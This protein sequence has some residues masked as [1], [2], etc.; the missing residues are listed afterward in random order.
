MKR[1]LMK[2]VFKFLLIMICPMIVNANN[3]SDD[4]V[5]TAEY[6]DNY[7][8]GNVVKC[9]AH[10]AYAHQKGIMNVSGKDVCVLIQEDYFDTFVCDDNGMEQFQLSV[11]SSDGNTY[12]GYGCRKPNS[13]AQIEYQQKELYIGYSDQP[14]DWIEDECHIISGDSIAFVGQNCRIEAVK[15]GETKLKV[16]NNSNR[17]IRYY[18]YNVLEAYQSISELDQNY[19]YGSIDQCSLGSGGYRYG[20]KVSF[21]DVTFCASS[22]SG[23]NYEMYSVSC[24]DAGYES[25]KL[26]FDSGGK[27]YKGYGC[28]QLKKTEQAEDSIDWIAKTIYLGEEED[29]ADY[30]THS[31]SVVSGDA[32]YFN[33]PGVMVNHCRL[34]TSKAGIVRVKAYNEK[35]SLAT[36]YEYN[37]LAPPEG[38]TDLDDTYQYKDVVS[39]SIYVSGGYSGAH[40]GKEIEIDGV[41]FCGSGYSHEYV[42][43]DV[44]CPTGYE[45]FPITL[46]YND[47]IY[48]A[49][50]CRKIYISE[51]E[52]PTLDPGDGVYGCAVI[53]DEI[54]EWINSTLN[55]VKYIALVLVIV[56]GILDFIKAAASGE[57][58]QMKK[59]G[60]SFLKRIIA[61]VILFLLPLIVELVLNLIEIYGADSTCL[62]N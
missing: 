50:G 24:K 51:P 56:L 54:R 8:Y 14:G 48:Y 13:E 6:D 23:Y 4:I 2:L 62:P 42:R 31:C 16:I 15:E 10:D 52:D 55:L 3:S 29:I 45:K 35:T 46:K 44:E 59:S 53:P 30:Y 9:W 1:I 49:Y 22:L 25:F 37:V 36:Y 5:Y 38:I 43:A 47:A 41:T 32:G 18:N 28:R 33:S 39:C 17:S 58:D 34:Y 20:D 60:S 26:V 19:N 27:H 12:V 7:T 21:G 40:V 57:A 61:V 11:S